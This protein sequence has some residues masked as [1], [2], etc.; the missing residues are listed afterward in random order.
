MTIPRFLDT[1]I[2]LY[3]I[4]R[5]P[6]EATKHDRA[7][8]LIEGRILKKLARSIASGERD[9]RR[10]EAEAMMELRTYRWQPD[11][12]AVRRQADLQPP[13]AED[14]ELVILAAA[15]LGTTRLIDNLEVIAV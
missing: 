6:T 2:L 5:D 3:S 10:L 14:R 11:Y 7:V 15:K 12:V 9:H 1:N 13:S 4:S 8:T